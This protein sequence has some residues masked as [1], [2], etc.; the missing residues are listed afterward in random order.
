MVDRCL[1]RAARLLDHARNDRR[2]SSSTGG[3]ALEQVGAMLGEV[4]RECLEPADQPIDPLG[5]VDALE[6]GKV[7]G[8]VLRAGHLV[9]RLEVVDVVLVLAK[10]DASDDL[11]HV[12]R[13]HVLLVEAVAIHLLGV[14][15]E[16]L[17]RGDLLGAALGRRIGQPVV[18]AVVAEDGGVDR[19]ASQEPLPEAVGEVDSLAANE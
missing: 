1:D 15:Q 6:A 10:P 13:D 9:H 12:E 19:L 17:E 8:H 11:E 18:V 5:R 2:G 7:A 4:L 16:A 14:G 3:D